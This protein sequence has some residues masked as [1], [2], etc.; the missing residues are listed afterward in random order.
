VLGAQA[1]TSRCSAGERCTKQ[2]KLPDTARSTGL[3]WL[4]SQAAARGMRTLLVLTG[5]ADAARYCAWVG[6][7]GAAGAGAHPDGPV[8]GAASVEGG[9]TE[10]GG[11]RR[12]DGA[13][14]QA[15]G[16]LAPELGA[17]GLTVGDFFSSDTVKARAP[18]Q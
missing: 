9:I 4:V 16:I 15:G 6:A 12:D 2:G 10:E 14:S 1:R 7:S 18:Y 8:A 13:G 11:A 3:D 5:G 17:G